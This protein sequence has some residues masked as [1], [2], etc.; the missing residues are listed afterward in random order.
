VIKGYN[1]S[2]VATSVNTQKTDRVALW[3]GILLLTAAA[4]TPRI[5]EAEKIVLL[6]SHRHTRITIST[7]AFAGATVDV[8]PDE[9]SNLADR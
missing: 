3:V 8:N 4:K 5:V 6:D 2:V 9:P 7:P 1:I